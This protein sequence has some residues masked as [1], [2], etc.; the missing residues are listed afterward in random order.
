MIDMTVGIIG[1]GTVGQ[2]TARAYVEHVKKV[3][4]YDEAGDR[5][6]ECLHY[7]LKTDI[8]FVCIPEANLDYCFSSGIHN[9][10]DSFR[11]SNLVIKS[12]VPIGTTRRLQKDYGIPNLVHSP[13]FLT[14]RRAT[15]DAQMPSRNIIGYPEFV[16]ID[17][18]TSQHPLA[19][20]Y[21][22]RFPY[23]P[24]LKMMSDE[25][26]AVKLFQN[27]FFAV[28]VSFWNE[29]RSLADK[30]G[31]DWRMVREAILAD[32]RIHPSHTQVPGP[33]GQRGFG[34]TCLP[35][36]LVTLLNQYTE[37][38]VPNSIMDAVLWRNQFVDRKE[39]K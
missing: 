27:A 26:E 20:L 3:R 38:E 32:G 18:N 13:E 1:G 35:K 6:T 4:V 39:D 9:H 22:Q 24:I 33:D 11:C 14:A 34:G 30:L 29:V 31:L 7:T 15:L 16:P 36:D 28:K 23:V 8:L 5:G 12:T 25:S 21:Q 37:H 10:G 19:D 2:A 17:E